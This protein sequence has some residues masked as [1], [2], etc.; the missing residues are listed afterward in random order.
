MLNFDGDIDVDANADAKR[1]QRTT[2]VDGIN[3][4]SF[5]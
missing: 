1:E 4:F 2:V 3:L 5:P